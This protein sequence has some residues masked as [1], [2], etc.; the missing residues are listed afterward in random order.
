MRATKR[1]PARWVTPKGEKAMRV[2]IAAAL[3]LGTS[4]I[5]PSFAQEPAKPPL[6]AP[7]TTPARPDQNA[8][9]PRDQ[10]AGRDPSR[11]DNREMGPDWRMRRGD[12]ER[13]DRDRRDMGF[14]GR[15]Q[16]DGG[17]L[18]PED[19]EIGPGP[20]MQRER[21]SDRDTER[22]WER[23]RYT[24]RGDRDGDHGYRDKD[25]RGYFD[26]DRPRRRIKICVEYENGDEYCR[27]RR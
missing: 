15:R 19:R 12:G 2:L 9:Q 11:T 22:N 16:G 4:S 10:R 14:E 18:G 24:E 17:R 26:E 8:E 3:L 7:Q 21:D 23:G 25:N 27:Y 13:T 1:E 5:C 20:G 6:E